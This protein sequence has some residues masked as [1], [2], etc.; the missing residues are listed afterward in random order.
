MSDKTSS[1]RMLYSLISRQGKLRLIFLGFVMLLHS[2]MELL[3]I[4]A[5][6]VLIVTITFPE[7]LTI[8]PFIGPLMVDFQNYFGENFVI[9]MSLLI[10]GL[11]V[12]K[13]SLFV[14]QNYLKGK[15]GRNFQVQLSSR[16]LKT[17]MNVPYQF[18]MSSNLPEL[19]RNINGEVSKVSNE[20]LIKLMTLVANLLV[21]LFVIGLLLWTDPLVSL[22]SMLL[23]SIINFLFIRRTRKKINDNAKLALQMRKA[24]NRVV[25]SSLNL[26]KEIKLFRNQE[27]FLRSYK[28]ALNKEAKIIIYKTVA[29]KMPKAILEV[30]AI[31]TLVAIIFIFH[32]TNKDPEETVGVLLVFS[33]ALMRLLPIANQVSTAMVGITAG[34]VSVPP[35][36]NDIQL[37]KEELGDKKGDWQL[38]SG[39]ISV[40]DLSF[41]YDEEETVLGGID[42]DIPMGSSIGLVGPSGS[43][44]STLVD[45]IMGLIPVGKGSITCNGKNI[46]D[47]IGD[48]RSQ[49]GYVPQNITL[50]NDSILNNVCIGLD[51]K[52]IDVDRLNSVLKQVQLEEWIN[53]LD[54]GLET[55][56]G[57]RGVKISGGQQQRIGIARALYHQPSIMVFDEATAALD[58]ITEK[59][60]V[61]EI[62]AL[63]GT[64]TTITIAHRLTT[65]K[66]CDMI[67]FLENGK[68]VQQGTY[69]ELMAHSEK[70]RNM[71][72]VTYE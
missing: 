34:L 67:Y 50:I 8:I 57:E 29:E 27:F 11:Y 1:L 72:K 47:A 60:I 26:I 62:E 71:N 48:W 20:V 24:K 41:S 21:G 52:K 33:V 12:V 44:K 3:G 46:W 49:F 16:L 35:V 6:P 9:F 14:F 55:N 61:E 59:L 15:I 23:F 2:G 66:N 43:G 13:S 64:V 30:A 10:I 4:G 54:E 18:H 42:L 28:R 31:S 25:L 63:K 7:R 58:N 5:I 40:S 69:S 39:K 68:I 22:T 51:D 53:T 19:I 56:L 65:V 36:Y 37:S 38:D 70:F 32:A 45:L 17:Y